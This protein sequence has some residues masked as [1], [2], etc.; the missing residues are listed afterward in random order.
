MSKNF[1]SILFNQIQPVKILMIVQEDKIAI[2]SDNKNTSAFSTNSKQKYYLCL[3]IVVILMYEFHVKLL[4]DKVVH[5]INI[6]KIK[7]ERWIINIPLKLII[8][9]KT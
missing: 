1:M 6:N 8:E 2:L 3:I 7:L 5:I 9:N 4:C